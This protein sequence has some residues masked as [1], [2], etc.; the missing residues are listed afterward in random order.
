MNDQVPF[1]LLRLAFFSALHS[2]ESL[3]CFGKVFWELVGG[4]SVLTTE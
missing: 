4:G 2:T 3:L 1:E